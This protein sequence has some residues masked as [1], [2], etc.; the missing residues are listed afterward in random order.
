[1]RKMTK[2]NQTIIAERDYNLGEEVFKTSWLAE[3]ENKKFPIPKKDIKLNE[4]GYLDL[5]EMFNL[6]ELTGIAND[7]IASPKFNLEAFV[8]R[9][10]QLVSFIAAN[11]IK[12]GEKLFY[13]LNPEFLTDVKI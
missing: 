10:K 5:D 7:I 1:M 6:V 2:K 4:K 13:S 8:N 11:P 9:E 12:K 3:G